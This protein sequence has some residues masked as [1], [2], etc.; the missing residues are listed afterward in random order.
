MLHP[1]LGIPLA[2][3]MSSG[4]RK[5]TAGKKLDDEDDYIAFAVEKFSQGFDCVIVGHSHN[6]LYKKIDGNVLL[7]LGDW[8]QNFSYGQL[9]AGELTLN[10]WND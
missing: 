8:I 7:N 1:D 6:P 9:E 2:K 4:S 3:F 5:H 10:Y